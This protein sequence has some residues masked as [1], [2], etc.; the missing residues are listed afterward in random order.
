MRVVYM[1]VLKFDRIV[2]EFGFSFFIF[3]SPFALLCAIFEFSI[4]KFSIIF[5]F[6]L[7]DFRPFLVSLDFHF[8]ILP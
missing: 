5:N 8:Q 3:W 6:K 1:R 4:F 7:S 2:F